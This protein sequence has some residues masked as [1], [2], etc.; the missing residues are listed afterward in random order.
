MPVEP[1]SK[2]AYIS[3]TAKIDPKTQVRC[4]LY[5]VSIGVCI[6]GLG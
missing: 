1:E 4:T 6:K 3:L 5:I 2:K